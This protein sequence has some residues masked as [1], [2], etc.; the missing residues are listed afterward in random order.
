MP[1]AERISIDPDD[2]RCERCEGDLRLL[3]ILPR[4]SDHPTFRIFE[5][6]SCNFI[7]WIAEKIA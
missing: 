7:N 2:P 3:T 6:A 5:C 4:A 1:D